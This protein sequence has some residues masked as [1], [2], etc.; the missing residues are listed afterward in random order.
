MF[1]STTSHTSGWDS[2]DET[3]VTQLLSSEPAYPFLLIEYITNIQ[4]SS[5]DGRVIVYDDDS[6]K[7]KATKVTI[8]DKK[9]EKEVIEAMT[10]GFLRDG[11]K[12]YLSYR[13]SDHQP[14]ITYE[15][16][17]PKLENLT[18]HLP[19]VPTGTKI[20]NLAMSSIPVQDKDWVVGVKLS[21]SRV[22][23]CRPFGSSKWINMKF[24]SQCIN[25]LSS[26]M[27]SKRDQRFYIPSYGGNYLCYLDLNSK[28]GDDHFNSRQENGQPSFI[29]LDYE[30]LPESVF[31]Q[32]AGVSSCSKTDHLVES[33]TGQLFLVKWF[34][35]DVED[36]CDNTPMHVT[37]KFMVFRANEASDEKKKTMIYT[38]DI[39]D[40]CIFLGH[41]EAFCIPA[42]TSC[43]LEPN[44]IYFVGNNFGVYDLTTETC[45]TF[46]TSVRP[47][48]N[49]S[50][51]Y[52]PPPT[53]IY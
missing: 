47:L 41:S 28:E 8:K 46:Y 51:P 15:T 11:L 31:K 2:D 14:V 30:N 26:L 44:C 42:S 20:H 4:N 12:F 52:W 49:V 48:K 37:K 19:S 36:L 22:S 3:K 18:I 38:E 29:D 33:P 27:F 21:G 13:S 24:M 35:E 1:S 40:L 50:F 5:S 32:L 23:L 53:P 7:G 25:P 16:S 34:V 6:S 45:S 9:L 43:G 17:N 10:V 39:G